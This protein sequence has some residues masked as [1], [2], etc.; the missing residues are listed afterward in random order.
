MTKTC[1]ARPR[2]LNLFDV[3][4][5]MP[6]SPRKLPVAELAPMLQTLLVETATAARQPAPVAGPR[7][8]VAR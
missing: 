2:Q 1:R 7:D 4:Q 8:E 3:R 5:P 6:V